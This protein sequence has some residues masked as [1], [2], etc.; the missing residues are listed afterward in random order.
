MNIYHTNGRLLFKLHTTI[1]EG[2]TNLEK[3]LF[4]VSVYARGFTWTS[5]GQI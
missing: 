1:K 2:V 3:K 5:P 4:T